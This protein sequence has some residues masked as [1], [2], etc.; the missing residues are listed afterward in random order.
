MN[1]TKDS[2]DSSVSWIAIAVVAA[3]LWYAMSGQS[4]TPGPSP[5]PAPGPAPVVS[6]EDATKAFFT[7]YRSASRQ[8][9]LDAAAK[10]EAKELKSD[11]AFFDYMRPLMIKARTESA[12]D[13]DVLCERDIPESFEGKEAEVAALIRKIGEAWK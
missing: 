11:R 2:D 7:K 6:Y 13:F 9:Y 4:A 12:K 3:V 5:T 10:V 8:V 1:P